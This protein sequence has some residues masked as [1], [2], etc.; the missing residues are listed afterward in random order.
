M[1]RRNASFTKKGTGRRP[2]KCGTVERQFE[3]DVNDSILWNGSIA[4]YLKAMNIYSS[5][6]TR[7]VKVP[8][9]PV[10]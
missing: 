6:P 7:T 4:N 2:H 5:S 8:V 1:G 3:H 10:S 9:A